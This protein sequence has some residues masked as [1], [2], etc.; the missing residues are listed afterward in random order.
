VAI[1][2]LAVE[3][4]QLSELV[5]SGRRAEAL[6]LVR[7]V[8]RT[9][10]DRALLIEHLLVP[11]ERHV[12]AMWEAGLL[13]IASS[14]A[15]TAI[16]EDA[17]ETI[18]ASV[19]DDATRAAVLVACPAG[20]WHSLPARVVRELLRLDGWNAE[21]AGASAPAR[22]LIARAETI[23][24]RVV[25]LSCS[26]P[27][28]LPSAATAIAA[29]HEGGIAVI[30][31]GAAFGT[32]GRRAGPVGADA[33]CATAAGASRVL[34]EWA[35]Q[36][37]VLRS[38]G[39]AAATCEA[40]DEVARASI[41]DS[42]L[43]IIHRAMPRDLQVCV[44]AHLDTNDLARLLDLVTVAFLTGDETVLHDEVAR[45]RRFLAARSVPPE[46]VDTGVIALADASPPGPVRTLLLEAARTASPP[47]G[48]APVPQF[49]PA[50][51]L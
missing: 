20:A 43:R 5:A 11:V 14:H 24:A 26:M 36:P 50:S 28:N 12:G 1:V 10:V 15:A 48:D 51:F 18:V 3:T 49:V 7:A 30:V 45:I 21:L 33:W 23:G 42:A 16:I 37:P 17:L 25:A 41:V 9:G 19:H 31:G 2:E 6:T 22:A 34:D 39:P 13:D 44:A 46:A 47:A 27:T 38:S 29:L 8:M 35:M 40:L 4:R 32:D